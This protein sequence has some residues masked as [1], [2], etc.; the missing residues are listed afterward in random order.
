MRAAQHFMMLVRIIGH[1][2][3][4]LLRPSRA[5]FRMPARWLRG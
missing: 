2:G 4:D 3:L 5:Q 1:V